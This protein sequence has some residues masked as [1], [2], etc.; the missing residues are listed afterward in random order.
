MLSDHW[1]A[2]LSERGISE[3]IIAERGYQEVVS[4]TRGSAD[5]AAANWDFPRKSGGMLI[6]LWP[7]IERRS[8]KAWD[9]VGQR[10]QLRELSGEP[11]F[12]S[13][14]GFPN[15]LA[16]HPRTAAALGRKGATIFIV[17]GVTRV[18]ALA[19]LG[20]PAVGI[21]G[22]TAWRGKLTAL[23][24]WEVLAIRGASII[25]CPDGDFH[26]NANVWTG[27]KR[28]MRWLEGRGAARVQI[29]NLPATHGLD[30]WI[31]EGKFKDGD[32]ALAAMASLIDDV[33]G[34]A[35]SKLTR[36]FEEAEDGSFRLRFENTLEPIQDARRVMR[37]FGDKLLV[38]IGRHE[39]TELLIDNGYGVWMR[40]KRRLME[41]IRKSVFT[42]LEERHKSG[43]RVG[44][45]TTRWL[46]MT[47]RR[48]YAEEV[49]GVSGPAL[50]EAKEFGDGERVGD[51]IERQA[52]EI[53][54]RT[55][56]IGCANGVIDLDTGT[57][58]TGQ[59]ARECLVTQHIEDPY[60]P[61]AKHWASDLLFAHLDADKRRWLLGALGYALRGYPSRRVYVLE[62]E[63]GGGKSSLLGALDASLGRLA[64]GFRQDALNVQMKSSGANDH[65]MVF[66]EARIAYSSEVKG[67]ISTPVIKQISGRRY[68]HGAVSLPR[69]TTAALDGH[70]LHCLQHRRRE[71]PVRSDRRGV[72]RTHTGV[73]LSCHP[74]SGA[75]G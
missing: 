65:L 26:S 32:A 34:T 15:V 22:V 61:T 53:D 70:S 46:N 11:K 66:T 64:Q 16:T 67:Q 75:A 72:V 10:Y 68:H 60:D 37:M 5:K 28:L 8:I 18:D 9:S 6:P 39:A 23:G 1:R 41:L 17:E 45:E 50:T 73:A 71:A 47:A 62:G 7:L 20:I 12:R 57:L 2:Y 24:D 52:R 21:A 3:D 19:T 31:A 14:P 74:R 29:L 56:F 59:Q 25:L 58:L 40:S 38:A 33:P 44:S 27:V 42:A 13:Q 43:E 63:P 4:G 30:D 48:A 49:S 55:K 51:V 36:P 35:P 54:L 69:L